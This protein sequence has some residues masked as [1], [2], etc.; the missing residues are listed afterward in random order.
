MPIPRAPTDPLHRASLS[1][2]WTSIRARQVVEAVA[3]DVQQLDAEYECYRR[4][5]HSSVK[6]SS[7]TSVALYHKVNGGV[8]RRTEAEVLDSAAHRK[9]KRV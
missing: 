8:R 6:I 1:L 5:Q 3:E 9:R 2:I 4:E 7:G